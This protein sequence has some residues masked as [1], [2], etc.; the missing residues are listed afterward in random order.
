MWEGISSHTLSV[1]LAVELQN[2]TKGNGTQFDF[3]RSRRWNYKNE[4]N[5][6][7]FTS[8]SPL[9]CAMLL[10][11]PSNVCCFYLNGY[12]TCMYRLEIDLS[13]RFIKWIFWADL[14]GIVFSIFSFLFCYGKRYDGC[15]LNVQCTCL[16]SA[17]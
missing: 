7:Q 2:Q 9:W 3:S 17:P 1:S 5:S 12:V 14:N 8:Q 6:T 10:K 16:F 11:F 15:R 13:R 4:I